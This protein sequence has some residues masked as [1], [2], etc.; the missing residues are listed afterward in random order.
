ML[1]RLRIALERR[2][3]KLLAGAASEQTAAA[4]GADVQAL[5]AKGNELLASGDLA[6]AEHWF[7]QALQ[8]SPHDPPSLVSL[9]FVLKEQDR[10]SEARVALRRAIDNAAPTD[11]VHEMHY[12]LGQISE[13][14]GDLVDARQH[15]DEALRLKPD[16]SLACK[17]LCR[18]LAKRGE[19]PAI[20]QTLEQCLSRS[21]QC[22]DYRLWLADICER[23]LDFQG[24]ADHLSAA[25]ELGVKMVDVHMKLGAALCRIGKV[26]EAEQT[27][28]VAQAMDPSVAYL[29]HYH[30]G[31]YHFRNGELRAGLAHMERSIALRPDFLA[32][33]SSAL[34]ALS[35][36]DP[37]DSTISYR[38]AAQRFAAAVRTTVQRPLAP[39]PP[40]DPGATPA[41]PPRLRVGF[42]SGDLY[43]HPVAYFLR[44]VLLQLDRTTLQLFAYSNNVLEDEITASLKT[45]FD[46]WHPIRA[47]NDDAAAELIAAHHIDL[48]LDLGGHTGENRLAIFAR[49]PAPT[50][51]SWL[52]YFASTGLPEMDYIIG[53]PVSTP[54]ET[55]E[56]FSEKVYRMPRTRLCMNIPSPQGEIPVLPP[57][58]LRNGYVTFG[59]YQQATK[60]TPRVLALWAR[61]LQAVPRSRLRIQTAAVDTP[62]MRDR[63]VR[64]LQQANIDLAR[65]T[66]LGSYELERYLESHGEVDILLD[67]FPYPG[68]T[69]TAFALWM[70]VPTVSLAGATMLARQGAAMLQ[71]VGLTDWIA[72]DESEYVDIAARMASAPEALATLRAELRARAL[73]SPLFDATGFAQDFQ[74]T[75]LRMSARMD[76]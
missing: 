34:L 54:V 63:L 50:Q 14:Q 56:W 37:G 23:D 17:D 61:I 11:D 40:Q 44:D 66:L 30:L 12:L 18:V 16:F 58:C 67:T 13:Q 74:T 51:V 49:R 68:G 43:R 71:C 75:L 21:P 39:H 24:V 59:S 47:L 60:I 69:T 35:H 53:D 42:V 19:Y 4:R 45:V 29:V 55:T 33:H 46:E 2:L 70:G 25:I 76:T 10:L 8:A 27:M 15:L 28:A 38:E 26:T 65:V 32:A 73:K 20:R 3:E 22:T 6:A 9:G 48:L 72:Q 62:S 57:P 36:V 64:D 52:G 7:R 41:A 1:D 5:R 31:Y